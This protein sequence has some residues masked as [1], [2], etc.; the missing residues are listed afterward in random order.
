M[1]KNPN[2]NP[3]NIL[4]LGAGELGIEIL[5]QLVLQGVRNYK[6]T[7]S[8]LLRGSTVNSKESEKT[9]LIEQLK[10]WDV[11]IVEGDVSTASIAE[12]AEVFKR[13]DTVVSC[14]GFASGSG[15]QLKLAQAAI[16]SGVSR[17]FP[18]QFGVE[19]DVIG[20]G[21][22]QPLFDEQLDVRDLLRGQQKTKWVIVST[23]MFTSF[24]FEPSFGVVDLHSNTVNALGHWDTQVTVTTPEDIGNLT[25][26]L[27]LSTSVENQVVYTAGDTLSY[28]QLADLLDTL[29]GRKLS[30]NEW[31]IPYLR[32]E[33][34]AAPDDMLRKYRLVFAQG[35]QNGPGVAW[36][37]DI[38][39]NGQNGIP[40]T[41][42]E[43]WIRYNLL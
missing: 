37:K 19:Y 16:S 17:Y 2:E 24:L 32:S 39:F 20:R 3:Q 8:V 30:R 23:G 25:A 43:G 14:V 31:T 40:V 28:G 11:G 6:A 35:N 26:M 7:V 34:A 38:S 1:I 9:Q 18:W 36:S 29:L 10:A 22:A 21:S 33:L 41:S 12:L 5:R 13:Y 15:T 42:V 27:V 4:V